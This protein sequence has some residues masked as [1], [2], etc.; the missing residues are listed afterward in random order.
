L[1]KLAFAEIAARFVRAGRKAP[2]AA[3]HLS[4]EARVAARE[5]R[6]LA[7]RTA[8][9]RPKYMKIPRA[10]YGQPA[11]EAELQSGRVIAQQLEAAKAARE[12]EELGALSKSLSQGKTIGGFAPGTLSPFQA[13]RAVKELEHQPF[14][15]GAT[16]FQGPVKAA[17][18]QEGFLDELRKIAEWL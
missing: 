9:G 11:T 5:A 16:I 12:A 2:S 14:S 4:P 1:N 13:S 17:S 8:T 3:L 18:F 6:L 15:G 10:V 7:E